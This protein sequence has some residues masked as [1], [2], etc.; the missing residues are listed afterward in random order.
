M[1]E[2]FLIFSAI[3]V[4]FA[5]LLIIQSAA[6][7][8][9]CV[10]C[11]SVFATWLG[12]ITFYWAGQFQNAVLIAPLLGASMIGVYYLTERKTK[13]RLHIF[14]LPFFLTL[15]FAVYFLL[16]AVES[17]LEPFF[18]LVVLWIAFGVVYAYRENPEVSRLA[19]RIIECCKNW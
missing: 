3:T 17:F 15:L 1:N 8:R 13:E 10:L 6:G 7:W 12:L 18:F 11:A 2:L 5:L 4:L 16:G 19:K 14:R 9:F